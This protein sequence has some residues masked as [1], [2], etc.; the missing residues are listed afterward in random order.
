MKNILSLM[1]FGFIVIGCRAQ[2]PRPFI[3]DSTAQIG[4]TALPH[5]LQALVRK[6]LKQE[7]SG[8][9]EPN[10]IVVDIDAR[11]ELLTIIF[12]LAGAPEFVGNEFA[13]Y[14]ALVDERFRPYSEHEAVTFARR[15]REEIGVGA[16][17]VVTLAAHLSPPP[18]LETPE[19]FSQ[20][21]VHGRWRSADAKAFAALA[22]DFA[23]ESNYSEFFDE[24]RPIYELAALRMRKL[25]R[26]EIE[27]KWFA[28]YFGERPN[29]SMQVALG[30]LNG[31]ISLGFDA[32]QAGQP[33]ILYAV[34]GI[35]LFDEYNL[36]MFDQGVTPILV[37]EFCHSFVDPAIVKRTADLEAAGIELQPVLAKYLP[38][39]GQYYWRTLIEESL[40][41]AAVARYLLLNNGADAAREELARQVE[42]G[43]VWIDNVYALLEEYE[44]NRNKYPTFEHFLPDIINFFNRLP[45]QLPALIEA[46][47]HR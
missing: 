34:M 8:N 10:Q 19:S 26:Q 37:H 6:H 17:G 16:D 22:K 25:V 47:E 33:D 45:D 5:D 32:K 44:Q 11:M 4:Q 21:A 23:R 3:V 36:P 14:A 7:W 30:L 35:W 31:N 13:S 43:F 20:T 29:S 46:I 42:N 1:L 39:M 40:V 12:R 18:Q 27:P 28:E 15:M 2:E 24:C 41:R 38:K 9:T